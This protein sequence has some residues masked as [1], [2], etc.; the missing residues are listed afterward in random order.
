MDVEYDPRIKLSGHGIM[1]KA[2][3]NNPNSLWKQVHLFVLFSFFHIYEEA[4]LTYV[5]YLGPCR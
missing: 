4:T 2:E 3:G 1:P 5:S